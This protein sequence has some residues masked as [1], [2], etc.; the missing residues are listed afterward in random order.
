MQATSYDFVIVGAGQNHLTAAAYLAAAGNSVLV[1]EKDDHYGGGCAS[2]EVTVPGFKHDIHATN[3]FIAQANPLLKNDELG[4]LSKF[5][6]AFAEKDDDPAQGCVFDDGS[7]IALYTDL[8]RSCESI[9][10]YSAKDAKAYRDFVRKTEK[11]IGLLEF[12]LFKPPV[13]AETFLG[14]LRGSAEGR[15]FLDFLNAPAWPLINSLFEEPRTKIHLL[16]L[17]SEMVLDPMQPGTAFG[18][19]FMMGLYHRYK[20][21]FAIGGSQSFSDALVR[22]LRHHGGEIRLNSHVKKVVVDNYKATGVETEDGEYIS[23]KLAVVGGFPPWQMA[24]YVEGTQMLTHKAKQVPAA[25]YTVFLTHLALKEAPQPNCDEQYHAMGFT[26]MA[27]RD[28]AKIVKITREVSDGKLPSEFSGAYVCATN[29][30][31]S[32]APAGQHTLYLYHLA[33]TRLN[34]TSMDAWNEVTDSFGQWL[35]ENTRKYVPNLTDDNILGMKHSSPKWIADS[36]ASYKY[37][38]VGSIGMYP[39]QFIYGRPIPELAQYRVPG[40][41]RLYLCGPFMH[42]GGGANGGGRATAIRIMMDLGMDLNSVFII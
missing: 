40:V 38:D 29:H 39:E 30:D 31:P 27:E 13:N 20:S 9:A 16:R 41:D 7:V 18:L 21:G 12:G 34:G 4:L 11:Y 3:I 22:C 6:L 5:G 8:E 33:P 10:K 15:E 14:I 42:P 36:S 1:L 2:A 32:R 28:T 23:A 26:T 24:D 35:L 17:M 37:G 25:D 19:L